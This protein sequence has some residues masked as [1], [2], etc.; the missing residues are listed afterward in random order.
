MPNPEAS[1]Y[2]SRGLRQ[3]DPLSPYLFLIISEVLSLNISKLVK[4]GELAGVKVARDDSLFFFKAKESNCARLKKILQEYCLA[5]GQEI[6]FRKSCIY[7][8]QNT[9]HHR[10]ASAVQWELLGENT[11]QI[12]SYT[13]KHSCSKGF[14]NKNITSTFL[15][16]SKSERDYFHSTAMSN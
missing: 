15:S 16:Q 11:Y 1:F 5:S 13:P 10:Q 14:H 12:K 6:N 7:F 4:E 2:P 8:S 3:G 9:L